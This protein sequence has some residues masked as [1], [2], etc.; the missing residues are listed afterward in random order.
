MFT[1][2]RVWRMDRNHR[3]INEEEHSNTRLFPL[4]EKVFK[5]RKKYAPQPYLPKKNNTV[6]KS[7]PC[8]F[9]N[10]A[11]LTPTHACS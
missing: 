8:T 5:M 7:H 4:K 6:N 11:P 9:R 1:L 10:Y 3:I 2:I